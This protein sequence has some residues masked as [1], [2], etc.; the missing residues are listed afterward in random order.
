MVKGQLFVNEASLT[1]ET[2]P[3]GK[4]AAEELSQASLAQKQDRWIFEG[5]KIMQKKTDV[6]A[7]VVNT[8]YTTRKGRIIRKILTKVPK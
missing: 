1:G 4:F 2:I 6:L 8:G 7:L 5:S 3:I